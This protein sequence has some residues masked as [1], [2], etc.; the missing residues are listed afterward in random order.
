MP[1]KHKKPFGLY[2]LPAFLLLL[3]CIKGNA[4]PIYSYNF[5][6]NITYGS[7]LDYSG[8]SQQLLMD[9]Y[10]AQ[11]G[12]MNPLIVFVHGGSFL[13]GKKEDMAAYCTYFAQR[14]FTAVTI[15]YRLG[16]QTSQTA[17]LCDGNPQSI[18]KAGYRAIQDSRAAIRFL[19][20]KKATYYIAPEKIFIG[21]ESAGAVTALA[22]AYM[23]QADCDAQIPQATASLGGLDQ[24]GNAIQHPVHIKGVVNLWGAVLNPLVVGA[25]EKIPVISFHG[26]ADDIVPYES[27]FYAGCP[28]FP[29]LYGSYI[30]HNRLSNNRTNSVL[31][32]IT[33]GGHGVYDFNYLAQNSFCFSRSIL[34]QEEPEGIYEFHQSNCAA[35]VLPVRWS[36][37]TARVL[38]KEII[39]AWQTSFEINNREFVIERSTDGYSFFPIGR[40]AGSLHAQNGQSYQYHDYPPETGTL[41]Y[42]LKQVDTD[43]RFAYSEVRKVAFRDGAALQ[44]WLSGDNLIINLA[45]G[46]REAYILWNP[47]GQAIRKGYLINGSTQ[48]RGMPAGVYYLQVHTKTGLERRTLLIP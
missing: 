46:N 21:G 23:D 12:T 24:S 36:S 3:Y 26:T 25:Q 34:M 27:G 4:Q 28:N 48:L 45:Q 29:F 10:T 31:H 30:L 17:N 14:G 32:K 18:E 22:T 42:R 2:L 20:E 33:G 39:I 7:A 40:V 1:L 13:E 41:F 16:W 44:C 47:N 35:I 5:Y 19:I 37:V 9:V 38:N 6:Q 15:N 11:T 43:G 8:A